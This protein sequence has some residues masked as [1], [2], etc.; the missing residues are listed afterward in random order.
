MAGDEHSDE[1]APTAGPGRGAHRRP[2]GTA[3]LPDW[4]WRLDLRWRRTVF[5]AVLV[6]VLGAV[7]LVV[8]NLVS[9]DGVVRSEADRFVDDLPDERVELWDAVAECETEGDWTS[10]ND[11]FYGGLQFTIESWQAVGGLGR[12]D[13][14]PRTEQIMRAEMLLDE[15]GWDAW[16]NCAAQLGLR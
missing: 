16:P 6:I 5:A 10:I 15:Q 8:N 13:Q 3:P 1:T 12:A 11:P 4:W 9:G 7:G 14:V 2:S